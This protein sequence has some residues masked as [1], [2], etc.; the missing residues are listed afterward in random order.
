MTRYLRELRSK[1]FLG[2]HP[3]L[4][5]SYSHYSLVLIHPFSDGNGRVARSLA[6]AFLYRANSI[7]VLSLNQDR[8]K[9]LSSLRAADTGC[10]REFID[11]VQ[12][13][14]IVS[15]IQIKSS[16]LLAMEL[17]RGLKVEQL[18]RR[19]ANASR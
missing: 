12:E 16:I 2:S 18:A 6:G 3:V 11:L 5:A 8:E 14:S 7:P 17:G 13:S 15:S 1:E 10:F 9:Y 19:R 4:Q